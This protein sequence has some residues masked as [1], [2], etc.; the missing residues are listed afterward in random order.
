MSKNKFS[1]LFLIC[2]MLLLSA[3][4]K[5]KMTEHWDDQ[6]Y[7]GPKIK[8]VLVLGLFKDDVNRRT[9]EATF[10][11]RFRSKTL[12]A[13]PGYKLMLKPDDYDT[14]E[15][16]I[17]AVEKI[18]ADA[19][20]VTHF[21]SSTLRKDNET[22]YINFEARVMYDDE[23]FSR[24]GRYGYGGYYGMVYEAVYREG[25]MI[26]DDIVTLETRLFSTKTGKVIWAGRSKSLNPKTAKMINKEL[27]KLI[28]KELEKNNFID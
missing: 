14:K 25:G 22:A 23:L 24:Y 3:C 12:Q 15:E 7:D 6:N 8:N 11:N 13:T 1:T 18:N 9:F 17:K 28:T 2:I 10:A 16:I 19:V 20:L 27:V 4:A 26:T 21:K 5:T